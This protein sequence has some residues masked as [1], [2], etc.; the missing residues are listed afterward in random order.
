MHVQSRILGAVIFAAAMFAGSAGATEVQST[1]YSAWLATV[2]GAPAE[3]NFVIPNGTVLNTAAGYNMTVGS[4]GPINVTGPDGSGYVLSESTSGG[5]ALV[6]A[7]DGVGTMAFATPAAGLTAFGLGVGLLGESAAITLTLSDGESFALDPAVNGSVFLGL[8]SATPI[9]S[10]V[11][12]TTAGSQVELNDF[13]GAASNES[14][15]GTA[16]AP[17]LEVATAIMVGTG[18]LFFG[19]RRKVFSNLTRAN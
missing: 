8:S 4:F 5:V 7:N 19:A 17:T 10:F 1:S 2:S 18:L 16:P 6:G 11:L 15:G 13:F 12:S 9:T 14:S 3:W